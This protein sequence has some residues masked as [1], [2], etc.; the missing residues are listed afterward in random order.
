MPGKKRK[1]Y[2]MFGPCKP[3]GRYICGYWQHEYEVISIQYDGN[4]DQRSITVRWVPWE[5]STEPY[6]SAQ[7]F[8][9]ISRQWEGEGYRTGTHMTSWD[10]RND[11]VVSQP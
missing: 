6:K 1:P 8:P 4:G 7:Q 11:T 9:R 5:D 3:G 2:V 10:N